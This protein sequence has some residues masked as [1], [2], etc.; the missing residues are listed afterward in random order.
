MKRFVTLLACAALTGCAAPAPSAAPAATFTMA[1]SSGVGV[2][3][4]ATAATSTTPLSGTWK[5]TWQSGGHPQDAE[6]QLAFLPDGTITINGATDAQSHWGAGSADF[7]GTCGFHASAPR[8]FNSC[9]RYT[10]AIVAPD[11]LEGHVTLLVNM[12]PWNVPVVGVL[13]HPQASAAN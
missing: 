1:P 7:A 10:L 5:L 8:L 11:R 6:L 9:E 13:E 12:A 3:H 2:A 4:F